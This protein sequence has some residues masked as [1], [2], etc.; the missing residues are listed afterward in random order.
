MNDWS[1]LMLD[2]VYSI[3]ELISLGLGM[4]KDTITSLLKNGP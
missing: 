1:K 4:K 2:S 3:T